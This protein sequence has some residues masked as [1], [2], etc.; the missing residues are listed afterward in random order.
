MQPHNSL[1]H[2]DHFH[3]RISCPRDAHASCI[4]L[5]KVAPHGKA[6]VAHKGHPAGHTLRTPGHVHPAPMTHA[7]AASGTAP[8]DAVVIPLSDEME[9]D[10]EH[11]VND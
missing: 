9:G 7:P 8:Q 4:E 11:D 1:P 6:R 10:G 3:V 5:A 2:D